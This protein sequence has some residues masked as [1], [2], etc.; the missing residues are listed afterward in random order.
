M[1]YS[2]LCFPPA[3]STAVVALRQKVNN[4]NGTHAFLNS[5]AKQMEA[6]NEEAV[7]SCWQLGMKLA[8][9]VCEVQQVSVK[10]Q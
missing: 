4:H 3:N 9:G 8:Q 10:V 6:N 7:T 5:E 1:N 2:A